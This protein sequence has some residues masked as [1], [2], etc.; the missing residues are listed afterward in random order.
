S[1]ATTILEDTSNYY[2]YFTFPLSTHTITLT[3]AT[4]G[5]PWLII[6]GII[7]AVGAVVAVATFLVLRQKKPAE[8]TPPWPES[9]PAQPPAPPPT[10][11]ETPAPL[12]GLAPRAEQPA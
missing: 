11:R 7:A 6:I 3:Y 10:P 2:L 12:G 5:L 1:T 4:A 8:Q 9:G